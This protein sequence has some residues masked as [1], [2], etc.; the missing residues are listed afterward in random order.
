[1]I[2]RQSERAQFITT[3]FRPELVNIADKHYG[4]EFRN[5]VSNVRVIDRETALALIED[6]DRPAGE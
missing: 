5:K 2:H 1:M 6:P 3:T 4:I